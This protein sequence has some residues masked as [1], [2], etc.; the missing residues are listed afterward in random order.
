[1]IIPD[2]VS[3]LFV[4]SSR[5]GVSSLSK[6][7]A[8]QQRTNI[9]RIDAWICLY[10]IYYYYYYCI[11]IHIVFFGTVC[12]L[13]A[14]LDYLLFIIVSMRGRQVYAWLIRWYICMIRLDIVVIIGANSVTESKS[15]LVD[16]LV[17]F[18]GKW[19]HSCY[20]DL[21]WVRNEN[22]GRKQFVLYMP[23]ISWLYLNW[24][25][26]RIINGI[27]VVESSVEY[28]WVQLRDSSTG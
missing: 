22:L 15:I 12:V 27:T 13:M 17:F 8:I 7:Y 3:A 1:M 23:H 2:D 24:A 19:R 21:T 4:I 28:L 20:A 6:S 16:S 10:L 18:L 11:T 26:F 25:N 9:Y 14:L 5:S